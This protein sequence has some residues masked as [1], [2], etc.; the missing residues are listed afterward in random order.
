MYVAGFEKGHKLLTT[1]KKL[2]NVSNSYRL[3]R[4]YLV[5]AYVRPP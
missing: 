4:V 2:V 5:A 1:S 3:I